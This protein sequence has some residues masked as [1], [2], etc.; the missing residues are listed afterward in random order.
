MRWLVLV[1]AL[2]ATSAASATDGFYAEAALGAS[3]MNKQDEDDVQG[4][5][6]RY[7]PGEGVAASLAAGYQFKR[8]RG[9]FNVSYRRS[10]G[11]LE[12]RQ[13]DRRLLEPCPREGG[14]VVCEVYSE[15]EPDV[16]NLAFMVNGYYDLFADGPVIPY[17]GAGIGASVIFWDART[18]RGGSRSAWEPVFAANAMAGVTIPF[19]KAIALTAGYRYLYAPSITVNYGPGIGSLDLDAESHEAMFGLR[20]YF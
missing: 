3:F 5:E 4:N 18:T 8:L 9:E 12:A 2:V 11:N 15:I 10:E 13:T 16:S 6:A 20:F 1:V 17:V 14:L 19:S 7:D